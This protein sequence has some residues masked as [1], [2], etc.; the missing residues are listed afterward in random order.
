MT[1]L[2]C[3]CLCVWALSSSYL[4]MQSDEDTQQEHPLPSWEANKTHCPTGIYTIEINI[5]LHLVFCTGILNSFWQSAYAHLRDSNPVIVKQSS[6]QTWF[7]W[8]SDNPVRKQLV[9]RIESELTLTCSMHVAVAI[10][11]FDIDCIQL[12]DTDKTCKRN[13]WIQSSWGIA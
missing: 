5:P 8:P 9:T 3:A 13:K 4:R 12:T 6:S 11:D 7:C 10:D 1:L 2:G